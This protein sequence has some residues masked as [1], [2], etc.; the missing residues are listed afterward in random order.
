M[1]LPPLQHEAS[2][3]DKTIQKEREREVAQVTARKC[4]YPIAGQDPGSTATSRCSQSQAQDGHDG[5][6]SD[7]APAKRYFKV[8]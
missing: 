3:A 4:M 5:I 7:V 1:S 6:G 8:H 2:V